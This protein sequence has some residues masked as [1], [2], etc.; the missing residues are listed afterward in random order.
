MSMLFIADIGQLLIKFTDKRHVIEYHLFG[1]YLPWV[2]FLG[3]V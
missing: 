2:S 3:R 1:G